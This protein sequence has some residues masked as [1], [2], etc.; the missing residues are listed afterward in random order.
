MHMKNVIINLIL[1]V[2]LSGGY[3][4]AQKSEIAIRGTRFEMN[5]KPFEYTGISFFNA[6]YNEEFNKNSEVR[7]E[8]MQKFLET[9]IN[10]LLLKGPQNYI[11]G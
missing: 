2:I 7:K 5:G 11:K 6:I 4:K 10:V 3:S 1:L 8:W 9:G